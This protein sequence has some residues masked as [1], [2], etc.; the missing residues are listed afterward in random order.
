MNYLNSSYSQWH[1]KRLPDVGRRR[2]RAN[3]GFQV[4]LP[5]IGEGK[6]TRFIDLPDKVRTAFF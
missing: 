4:C 6:G 2:G 5:G 1:E 3:A